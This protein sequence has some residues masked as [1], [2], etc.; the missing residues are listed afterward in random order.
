MY[1][2]LLSFGSRDSTEGNHF[3]FSACKRLRQ[4]LVYEFLTRHCCTA[5]QD[6]KDVIVEMTKASADFMPSKSEKA[7]A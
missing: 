2:S 3:F 6:A 4:L 1:G 5:L 7:E